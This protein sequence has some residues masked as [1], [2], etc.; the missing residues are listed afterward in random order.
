MTSVI[1]VIFNITPTLPLVMLN[2][3]LTY[4]PPPLQ[5]HDVIYEQSLIIV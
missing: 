5:Q 1:L 4:P 2:H 3:F